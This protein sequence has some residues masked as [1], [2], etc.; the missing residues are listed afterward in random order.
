M[1]LDVDA[2]F[3]R[4]DYQVIVI[5][6]PHENPFGQQVESVRAWHMEYIGTLRPAN[7]K[8]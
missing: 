8:P 6:S 4:L 1:S 7:N 2:R 3:R 5:V